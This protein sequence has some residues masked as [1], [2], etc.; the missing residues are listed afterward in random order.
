L[1]EQ[2]FN[3][4]GKHSFSNAIFY[5]N[6]NCLRFE[7]AEGGSR[8]NQFV[9][10]LNKA[11]QLLD[12]LFSGIEK[13]SVCI[14]FSG[15]RYIESKSQ[16]RELKDLGIRIPKKR[17]MLREWVEDE[18]WHRNYLIFDID[19]VDIERLLFGKIGT[20]LGISPS[21]WFDIYFYNTELGVLAHPYDDRGMDVV[22]PNK[23]LLTKLYDSRNQWLLD[24][25]LDRMKS[26]FDSL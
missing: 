12:E 26:W 24:Y 22:G 2:A 14:A 20:E 5:S 1:I 6:E 18:E 13:V 23:S 17:F 3:L 19:I 7:L 15:E 4:F 9:T 11:R 25:D 21:F 10:A 16:F 8:T